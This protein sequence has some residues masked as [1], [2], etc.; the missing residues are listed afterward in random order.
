MEGEEEEMVFHVQ[1]VKEAFEVVLG[2][3]ALQFPRVDDGNNMV[4]VALVFR[5]VV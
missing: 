1:E 3:R 4:K 5:R 2:N